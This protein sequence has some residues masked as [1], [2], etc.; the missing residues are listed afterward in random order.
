MTRSILLCHHC[1]PTAWDV[2]I[3]D[4][5]E[6]RGFVCREC[7]HLQHRDEPARVGVVTPR[8]PRE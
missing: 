1:G 6:L 3:D 7:G 8:E 2:E 5:G 4:A